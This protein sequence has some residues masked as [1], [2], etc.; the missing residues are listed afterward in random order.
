MHILPAQIGFCQDTIGAKFRNG[1]S[2]LNTLLKL[3]GGE[4]CVRQI[5]KM[6]VVEHGGNFFSMSN[7]RLCLYRLCEHIGLI[8]SP[9]LVELVEKPNNFGKKFTTHCEG[10]WVRVRQDGRTC[11]RTW[12]ETTF[13]K[14]ELFGGS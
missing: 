9:I 4:L 7:R 3:A 11:A 5:P 13:G 10:N 1:A 8:T 14:E 6:E 2:I 12:E